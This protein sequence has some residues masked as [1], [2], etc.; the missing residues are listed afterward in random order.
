[1]TRVSECL[2]ARLRA[3]G[4]VLPPEAVLQRVFPSRAQRSEGA[5]SWQAMLPDC[6]ELHVGS[7][8]S[9]R[10]LLAADEWIISINVYGDTHIDVGRSGSDEL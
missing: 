4:V 3:Q 9:M 5:W 1:M 7:Q 6:T 8:F 2:L 10:Q